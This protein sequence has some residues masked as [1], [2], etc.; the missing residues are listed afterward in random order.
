[1]SE[2]FIT[3]PNVKIKAVCNAT[4]DAWLEFYYERVSGIRKSYRLDDRFPTGQMV[5]V[6]ILE[7]SLISIIAIYDKQQ[8]TIIHKSKHAINKIA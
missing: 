6:P 1:M 4:W 7:T 2:V 8:F 5:Y 3:Y